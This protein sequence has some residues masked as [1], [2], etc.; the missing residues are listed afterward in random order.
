[1]LAVVSPDGRETTYA[2]LAATT[3][4]YS[5]GLRSLGLAT[6]DSVAV[7][8]PNGVEM[9]ALHVQDTV[10]DTRR[11]VKRNQAR[12]AVALDPQ[13]TIGNRLGFKGTP[14]TVVIDKK[15]EMI[16]RLHGASVIG[17][18]PKI[19]DQALAVR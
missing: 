7:L 12:Y 19:L 13:L 8:L 4:R 15:G 14:Y 18:P 11:F 5:H 1:M 2:E 9:L 16:A 3:N 6:G 10:A 17:R